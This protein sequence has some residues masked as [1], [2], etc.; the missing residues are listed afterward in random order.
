[1]LQADPM[2]RITIT[3][4]K[5][6]K[7]FNNQINLYQKIDNYKYLYGNLVEVDQSIIDFMKSLDINFDGFDEEKIKAS[8]MNRERKEFCIIYEYL[9]FSKT[10]KLNAEK[11]ETLKSIL[12][13]NIDDQHFFKNTPYSNKTNTFLKK[14][15]EKYNKKIVKDETPMKENVWRIGIICKKDCYYI[16]T[17]ILKC[18]E[19]NG[20]EWKIISSSY[21]IKCRRKKAELKDNSKYSNLNVLIQIFSVCVCLYRMLIRIIKMNI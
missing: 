10:K 18:L 8:I 15:K 16:T 14:L 4:I 12:L 1:M 19:R 20:Y 2:N 7:W 21:K 6:H 9:E 17:E 5:Q 13:I 3:E 11:K